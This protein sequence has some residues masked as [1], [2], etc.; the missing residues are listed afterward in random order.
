MQNKR[1]SIVGKS[2]R[3]IIRII[4]ILFKIEE[5]IIVLFL[6]FCQN[7]LQ[8]VGSSCKDFLDTLID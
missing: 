3:S 2:N 5:F 7:L 8:L 4:F 6:W 1:I